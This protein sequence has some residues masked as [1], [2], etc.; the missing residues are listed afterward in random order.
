MQFALF[1]ALLIFPTSIY[2]D[3][4]ISPR[5]P[6]AALARRDGTPTTTS[7]AASATASL[8]CPPEDRVPNCSDCGSTQENG[9]S[10]ICTGPNW[11]GCPCVDGPT[12]ADALDAPD[13]A[14]SAVAPAAPTI[15]SIVD[16]DPGDNMVHCAGE[17]KYNV[18]RVK[19]NID[20]FCSKYDGQVVGP[21]INQ[22]WYYNGD[23]NWIKFWIG[24]DKATCGTGQQK[25]EKKACLIAMFAVIKL[26]AAGPKTKGGT[27]GNYLCMNY[28]FYGADA[29]AAG[30]SE[31]P[32][33]YPPPSPML[34]R[35]I[36]NM[37][38]RTPTVS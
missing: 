10:S 14:T 8:L 5:P 31:C 17:E 18:F 3:G 21:N 32:V 13:P 11:K 37:S 28:G 25:I 29:A 16:L 23:G 9:E 30:K 19:D 15:T 27:T 1:M 34:P 35:T 7:A 26:C 22:E 24:T 12:F 36:P 33:S 38:S 4:V 2:S 6:A 20:A